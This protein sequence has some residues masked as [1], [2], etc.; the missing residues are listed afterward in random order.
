MVLRSTAGDSMDRFLSNQ[1]GAIAV[2]FAIIAIPLIALG[3]WGVDYL[4]LY[5]VRDA[6]QAQADAAVLN[7]LIEDVDPSRGQWKDVMEAQLQ[8]QYGASGWA[9]NLRIEGD[10]VAA[11]SVFRVTARADVPLTFMKLIPGIPE[12]QP[13]SV[14]AVAQ[15]DEVP[16]AMPEILVTDLDPEAGDFNRI[17]L[18]CFWPD[19]RE[20]VRDAP[21]RTQMVPIADNGGSGFTADTGTRSP[22]D[23]ELYDEWRLLVDS[24]ENGLDSREEGIY[25]YTTGRGGKRNY[26]Y[27]TPRC[28][29]GSYLSYRLENVRF[30][31]T[32][33]QYWDSGTARNPQS[34]SDGHRGR[35]NYYTDSELTSGQPEQYND[36]THP[37]TGQRVDILETVLCDTEFQCRNYRRDGGLLPNKRANR[38]PERAAE[39]CTPENAGKYMYYGWEDR[40]PGQRGRARDWGDYAWTDSDYDDIRILVRCPEPVVDGERSVRLIR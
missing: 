2:I 1:D 11:G 10:W 31:R 7:A 3:G 22:D 35:F 23:G 37:D 34:G 21:R 38:T 36:L 13:V 19:R 16:P 30:A 9:G 8:A 24:H 14:Q 32:Q 20:G 26:I 25:R 33:S 29:E 6:L 4:R 27:F 5:H 28:A 40:P 39:G 15:L 17:W 12:V 18:Y